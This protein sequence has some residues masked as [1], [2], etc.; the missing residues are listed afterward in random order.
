VAMAGGNPIEVVRIRI[1]RRAE[2]GWENEGN[3]HDTRR[4][5]AP[6]AARLLPLSSSRSLSFDGQWLDVALSVM[7]IL[8]ARVAW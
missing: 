4:P 5:R 7:Q 6:G 3:A 1:T 2:G 8:R